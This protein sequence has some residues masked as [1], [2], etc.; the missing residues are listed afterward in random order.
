MA[1]IQTGEE[2]SAFFLARACRDDHGGLSAL[3]Q[4]LKSISFLDIDFFGQP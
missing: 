2:L 4:H 3:G 1:V